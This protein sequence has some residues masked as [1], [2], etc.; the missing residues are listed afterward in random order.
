MVIRY[1]WL[2]ENINKGIFFNEMYARNMAFCNN[3]DSIVLSSGIYPS[4][5]N[6]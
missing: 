6:T 1:K 2:Q 4:Q 5:G 3:D